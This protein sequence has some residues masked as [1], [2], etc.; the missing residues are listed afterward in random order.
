MLNAKGCEGTGLGFSIDKPV[1]GQD[2]PENV[3]VFRTAIRD[4]EGLCMILAETRPGHTD[5]LAAI[6]HVVSSFKDPRLTYNVNVGGTLNLFE[7]V[8][9]PELRPRIVHVSTVHVYRS[10]QTETGL[11]ESAPVRLLTLDATSKFMCEALATQYAKGFG[12]DICGY[13]GRD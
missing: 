4:Y 2:L 3:E 8:Q 9:E 13:L 10:S 5:H 6:A 7:A 11:D 1:Q 12:L